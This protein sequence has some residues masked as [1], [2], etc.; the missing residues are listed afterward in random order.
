MMVEVTK[1]VAVAAVVCSVEGTHR[2]LG[3]QGIPHAHRCT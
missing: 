3:M 2:L 1:G